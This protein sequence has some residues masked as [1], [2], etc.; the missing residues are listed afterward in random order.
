MEKV[1][2]MGSG[3]AGYTAA[4]Y[5]ARANLKPLILTGRQP[6]GLLTTTSVVE[7][8]PGFPEGVDGYELMVRM[9]KQAERFG[10]RVKFGTVEGVDL[11]KEPFMLTVDGETVETETLI[12]A[13]GASHRHLGLENEH[14]LENKGV[15]YCATCDGALPMFRNKPLVVVG[16]GDSACEEAMYLTRFA[17]SVHLIHR[18]D[19][20]RAS[21]IMADRTLA[22][23]KIKPIWDSAV[24]DVLD[25]K[26]DK[27]T[28]VRLKNLKTEKESELE[29]AGLF[30]A[31]GHIPNTQLFRGVIDM[32]EAG[33]F[34]PKHGTATNVPGVFVAGDCADRVYRQAVTAAGTGCAAAIDVER[35]LAA[36]NE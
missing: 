33:Y 10:A 36:R 11:D 1:V 6:G 17:S 13:S 7:N 21:K 30:V 34:I 20:L 15:T 14:K 32:D 31:I 35:W 22:H 4:L 29:A 28:G 18:R 23:E 27:V 9:Q 26:Q 19:T 8:Y 12:I 24:T 5:T 25:V 3:C 2:I 16:G